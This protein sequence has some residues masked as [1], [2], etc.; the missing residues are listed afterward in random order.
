LADP[1]GNE[2]EEPGGWGWR[3]LTV[4]TGDHEREEWH[5]LGERV[6]WV[7]EELRGALVENKG[8]LLE[9]LAQ[10]RRTLGEASRHGLDI[11]WSEYP[12]WIE[13][14]DPT[15]GE[16][17]EVR[18]AECLAGIIENADRYRSKGG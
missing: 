3:R 10:E 4:G 15:T 8:R 6:G 11:R 18:A 5:L 1:E 13:L 16:W 17:H 2:P 12:I 9:L 7:E 14:H